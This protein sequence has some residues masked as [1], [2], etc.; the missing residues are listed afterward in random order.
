MSFGLAR[1]KRIIAGMA[2]ILLMST[3]TT[4]VAAQYPT[5]KAEIPVSQIFTNSSGGSVAGTFTY[6][7]TATNKDNPMPEGI[8]VG[9]F[10]IE[11]TKEISLEIIF[12]RVGI[13][14]YEI[15]Q[16][17]TGGS[18]GYTYDDRT[19]SVTVYV[20]NGE[21]DSLKTEIFLQNPSGGKV[22]KIEFTNSYQNIT[23]E[24]VTTETVTTET[25]TTED[26]TTEDETTEDDNPK[27][28][29]TKTGD[30]MLWP[31]YLLLICGTTFFGIC[32]RI[33]RLQK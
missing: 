28:K 20:K 31:Y 14:K 18:T 21:N 17:A 26:K 19:Y 32:I 7:I 23:T 29:G 10:S 27:G 33:K 16:V 11:E 2:V 4:A 25:V 30:R 9:T 1:L 12:D 8:A 24:T 3:Q 6:R 5:A 22:E 13:Y 15:K